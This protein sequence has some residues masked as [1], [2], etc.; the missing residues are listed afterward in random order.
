M[1]R[2]VLCIFSDSHIDRMRQTE[3]I[4]NQERLAVLT[5]AIKKQCQKEEE[6]KMTMFV[7]MF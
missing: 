5:F 2:I 1:V 3:E 4:C 6:E 7:N